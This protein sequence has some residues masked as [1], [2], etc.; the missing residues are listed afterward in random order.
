MP[1][2][3]LKVAETFHAMLTDRSYRDR[4]PLAEAIRQLR[5]G[6]GTRYDEHVVELL[7]SGADSYERMLADSRLR[8]DFAPLDPH[9]SPPEVEN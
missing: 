3:I 5:V 4:L 1:A 9:V 6:A 8:V 2:R 7:G